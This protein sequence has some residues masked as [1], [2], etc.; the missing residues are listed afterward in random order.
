MQTLTNMKVYSIHRNSIQ[1]LVSINPKF[2]VIERYIVN[3][4]V[5]D[6][7]ER[8]R[9]FITETTAE[10]YLKLI[11]KKQHL[12]QNIPLKILASYT[13]ITPESL[14]RLRKRLCHK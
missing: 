14:N 10:R 13:G 12:I 11:K 6:K 5:V 2:T 9:S 7:T 4:I 1:N 8:L 3:K